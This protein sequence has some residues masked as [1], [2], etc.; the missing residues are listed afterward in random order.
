[1]PRSASWGLGT[2]GHGTNLEVTFSYQKD[3]QA[4]VVVVSSPSNGDLVTALRTGKTSTSV[5]CVRP[6]IRS[7][8]IIDDPTVVADYVAN[9]A[10]HYQSQV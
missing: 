7:Q 4:E 2:P 10:D 1:M 6:P 9:V 8:V 3:G 5:E